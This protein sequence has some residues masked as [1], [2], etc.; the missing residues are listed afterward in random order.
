MLRV[1]EERWLASGEGHSMVDYSYGEPRQSYASLWKTMEIPPG[2]RLRAANA[3]VA[4]IA[5][6]KSHYHGPQ[7]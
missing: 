5:T 6:G 7:G 4:I 3:Q 1:T 2:I